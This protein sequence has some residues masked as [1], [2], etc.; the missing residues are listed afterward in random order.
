MPSQ[1]ATRAAERILSPHRG[2]TIE[3][4]ALSIDAD[5]A[6]VREA[7]VTNGVHLVTCPAGLRDENGCTCGLQA[8][9]DALKEPRNA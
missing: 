9:L 3:N 2:L 1:I 6:P 5:L 8:A 4:V 7:L